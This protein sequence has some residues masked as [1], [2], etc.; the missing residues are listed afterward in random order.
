MLCLCPIVTIVCKKRYVLTPPQGSMLPKVFK[1]WALALEGTFSLNPITWYKRVHAP[2][3]WEKAYPS[4]QAVRPIW[5]TFDDHWV[6]EV[7]RGL[8]ACKVFLWFPIYW[9]AYGQMTVS[10]HSL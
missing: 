10:S 4:N 1:V 5:M 7:R 2:G 6:D 9:L 3:L 8:L